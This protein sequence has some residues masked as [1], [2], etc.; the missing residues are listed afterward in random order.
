MYL[1]PVAAF[2]AMAFTVSKF[3]LHTLIPLGKLLMSVYI[4]MGIFIF[5]V[6]GA[7]MKYYGLS[8][9]KFLKL[10]YGNTGKALFYYTFI[11][12]DLPR[13]PMLLGLTLGPSTKSAQSYKWPF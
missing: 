13:F 11:L 5:L 2:G 8:N 3:G 7:I 6:L 12:K 1:A 9:W 4:T 10:I